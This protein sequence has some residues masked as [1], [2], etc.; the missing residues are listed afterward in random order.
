MTK[1]KPIAAFVTNITVST[2]DPLTSS[3]LLY[4]S[5]YINIQCSLQDEC[6]SVC[7]CD[8]TTDRDIHINDVLVAQ[9]L[10]VFTPDTIQDEQQCDTIQ[11]DPEPSEVNY[12]LQCHTHTVKQ[13][14]KCVLG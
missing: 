9:G 1:D 7:L 2:C 6:V 8:T 12:T 5:L 11:L 14:V 4:P 3:L 13:S 10:A